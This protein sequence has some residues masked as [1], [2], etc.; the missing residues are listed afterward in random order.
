MLG[1]KK[2][3]LEQFFFNVCEFDQLFVTEFTSASFS[4]HFVRRN[5]QKLLDQFSY[6][7]TERWHMGHERT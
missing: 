1:E 3:R 6:N 7:L 5:V 2:I 4:F